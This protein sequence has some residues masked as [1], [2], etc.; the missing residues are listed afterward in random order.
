M[1]C[2][3]H[4]PSCKHAIFYRYGNEYG[5]YL[6]EC[7]YELAEYNDTVITSNTHWFIAHQKKEVERSE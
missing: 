1:N 4:C 5:C 6:T 7:K 2:F 3:T